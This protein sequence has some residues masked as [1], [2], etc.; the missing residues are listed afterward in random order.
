MPVYEAAARHLSFKKAAEE[1]FVTAPAVAQQVKAFESWLGKPLFNRHAR[2][3]SLTSEG[4]YY[5]QV[6]Q[7]LVK[8]HKQAYAEYLRRFDKPVLQ[9]SA[10]LFLAHE[11][12]MPDYLR[13]AEYIAGVELRVEA[14]TSM[15]DFDVEPVDA[16]IRAGDG[17]W[18][19][20]DC[21]HLCEIFVSPV[22]SPSYQEGHPLISESGASRHRFLDAPPFFI[23]WAAEFWGTASLS[24][25]Q[26]I[27]CDSYMAAL[28]AAA[29]GLGV[30]LGLFPTAN[31]WVNDGRLVAPLDVRIKT[32]KSYWLVV[33]KS[34]SD[35]PEID[36]L[37]RWLR[38]LFEAI[39]ELNH[40]GLGGAP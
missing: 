23:S 27:T 18:P 40:P 29:D 12:L 37:H 14:R 33:P 26:T 16:A 34:D 9:V 25:C 2:Q 13:F 11:I 38:H 32:D 8:A 6:A 20:L 30:A 1:L 5:A 22:C 39:P 7:N 4:K 19:E 36:A 17:C 31:K 15:V 21:Y 35:R 24:E 10:P 3:L 28:K